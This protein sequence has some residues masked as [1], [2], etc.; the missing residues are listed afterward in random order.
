[1]ITG[2][3]VEAQ[4]K[5]PSALAK[6]SSSVKTS[7]YAKA[8]A[9]KSE[10][11][12]KKNDSK[13]EEDQKEK[14]EELV[15]E[16]VTKEEFDTDKPKEQ[17]SAAEEEAKD[18]EEVKDEEPEK[19][20]E[21]EEKEPKEKVA[22]KPA[23]LAPTEEEPDKEAGEQA[24]ED[25]EEEPATEDE[26]GVQ[27]DSE[28]T[29]V[30][31]ETK[32]EESVA[33]EEG[34][35]EPAAKPE[36]PELGPDEIMGIDTVDLEDPQG[37]WLYK[38]V[39]WERA[40]AKYEKIRAAVT[41]MLELRT[42]FFAKRA[43]LDKNTL[44]PFYVKTGFSQGEL[45]QQLEERIAQL[46]KDIENKSDAERLEKL[47]ADKQ[48]LED[49]RKEVE[50]VVKQDEEVENAILMLVEQ[51]NKMRNYE[52]QAWQD[53][54]NIARVLDDKKARELFYKVD[55]AWRN[56]Q[57]LKQYVE[58]NFSTG[59][60]QLISRVVQ[61]VQKVDAAMQ[62]LKEKGIELKQEEEVTDEGQ[63]EE[64][65]QGFI[66]RFIITPISTVFRAIWDVIMWP[67]RKLMGTT[68]PA[69]EDVEAEVI[70]TVEIREPLIDQKEAIP[71]TQA[72]L[73][74]AQ[75][76]SVSMTMPAEE[77]PASLTPSM[78][79]PASIA[80]PPNV[81]EPEPAGTPLAEGDVAPPKEAEEEPIAT[82]PEGGDEIK[83]EVIEVN[84][85]EPMTDSLDTTLESEEE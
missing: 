44:D 3:I 57:E 78:A 25:A 76:P 71:D 54:K 23:V 72:Q 15:V 46:E 30:V 35:Q 10:D 69:V 65:P 4:R 37:N 8:S 56:I 12:K 68:A 85:E 63:E 73:F 67:I 79:R 11:K 40:E 19:E 42:K 2:S 27:E 55:G 61:Q 50:L 38:R 28:E 43:E 7:S 45:K 18:K 9:D 75:P 32:K 47:E 16:E 52:Q 84:E 5:K 62:Q 60:E 36:Q 6:A 1:M 17:E 33:E 58:S 53:F 64:K 34:E 21:P 66:S 26:S 24:A 48:T 77:L 70:E 31:E 82:A 29:P 22:K 74:G 83:E 14:E 49:L 81:P 13:K 39:W 59:F 41:S 51:S 20:A 80:T